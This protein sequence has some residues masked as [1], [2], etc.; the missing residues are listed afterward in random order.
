MRIIS[1]EFRG[2]LLDCPA[3]DHVR[4]TSDRVR[5]NLFNLL[6]NH[7]H[8][9]DLAVADLFCGSG[10]L[11]AESL[12]RGAAYSVFVDNHPASVKTAE[13]NLIRLKIE[14]NR[15]DLVRSDAIRWA[16]S[17]SGRDIG[18]I[19]ADPPYKWDGFASLFDTLSQNIRL[20]RALFA[21]EA[22][23]D[24]KPPAGSNPVDDRKYGKTRLCLFYLSGRNING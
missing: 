19:F 3:G 1:G 18:V 10:A 9:Q 24:F 12:S 23:S 17:Y 13:Q 11:G 8:F 14:K 4:P 16:G 15:Y 22:S 6:S 21:F 20:N 2:R 7:L 5:E